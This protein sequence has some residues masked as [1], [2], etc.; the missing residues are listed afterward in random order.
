MQARQELQKRQD[1]VDRKN[2]P[3]VAFRLPFPATTSKTTSHGAD[4]AQASTTVT[5]ARSCHFFVS[6]ALVSLSLSVTGKK[7]RKTKR[8]Q[9]RCCTAN[10]CKVKQESQGTQMWNSRKK[11]GGQSWLPFAIG[12]QR[13]PQ[14]MVLAVVQHHKEGQRC[15]GWKGTPD[16]SAAGQRRAASTRSRCPGSTGDG[17]MGRAHKQAARARRVIDRQGE[18]PRPVPALTSAT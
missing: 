15:L 14:T 5:G 7:R 6:C 12:G 11:A 3:D 16:E 10:W 13:L 2:L 18:R 4:P 17:A 9:R 8:G 1:L